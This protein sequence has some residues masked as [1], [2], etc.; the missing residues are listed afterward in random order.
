M[1]N[2]RYRKLTIL[3]FRG[4][5]KTSLTVQFVEN[6]FSDNYIPTIENSW[7]KT[8]TIRGKTYSVEIV[9]TAGQDEFSIFP[10]TYAVGI[11]GYILVYSVI[12]R[13]SFEMVRIIRDKILNATGSATVPMVLV[14]NKI[15]LVGDRVISTQAGQKLANEW[16][17]AFVETSAK[18]NKQVAEIFDSIVMAV[19]GMEPESATPRKNECAIQ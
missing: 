19:D 7:H 18:H 15:D 11:H 6:Q 17:C 9:D 16:N 10:S 8:M 14:G 1:S 2:Q 4:V 3:G 5:G 13:T 12:S